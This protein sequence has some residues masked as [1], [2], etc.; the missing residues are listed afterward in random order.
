MKFLYHYTEYKP[1]KEEEQQQ[2]E[3]W[4]NEVEPIRDDKL[5]SP[6][7]EIKEEEDL[8]NTSGYQY[9]EPAK[10]EEEE[11]DNYQPEENIAI[12][13]HKNKTMRYNQ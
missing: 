2:I 9:S 8:P 12:Q 5:A 3:D 13:N 11:E 6:I 4:R 1:E 10:E 7:V